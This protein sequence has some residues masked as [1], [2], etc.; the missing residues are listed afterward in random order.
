MNQ[1]QR[2]RLSSWK[3]IAAFVGRTESTVQRWERREGMPVHRHL[4]GSRSTVYAFTDEIDE[5]LAA[6]NTEHPADT[7]GRPAESAENDQGVEVPAADRSPWISKGAIKFTAALL[8]VATLSAVW[9]R[10][11]TEP[12]PAPPSPVPKRLT[13]LPGLERYPAMSPDGKRVAFAWRTPAS[14]N[15][16]IYVK[17]LEDENLL[18]I[19]RHPA[20]EVNPRWSP[21]GK[22]ISYLR[23]GAGDKQTL[24]TYLLDANAERVDGE[25]STGPVNR[26]LTFDYEPGATERFW[27]LHRTAATGPQGL[28]R[29]H[30]GKEPREIMIRGRSG[31]YGFLT[32][33]PSPGGRHVAVADAIGQYW[34]PTELLAGPKDGSAWRQL[35]HDFREI[36]G[37]A[38]APD[39]R[40]II[41]SSTRQGRPALFRIAADA[42]ERERAAPIRLTN[43]FEEA[44]HPATAAT[45]GGILRPAG[46]CSALTGPAHGRRGC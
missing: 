21:T 28:E 8:A 32:F 10:G 4:H 2:R 36:H 30:I 1:P 24:I 19:S 34:Q 35:T 6:R 45:S 33:A 44:V 13:L 40:S 25:L 39:G 29:L 38:W 15:F 9:F 16:D 26:A 42:P 23:E 37:L 5:W 3:E 7:P 41:F 11:G 22:A 12:E 43:H 18:R 14:D 46:S 20:N 31:K 27:L 17:S